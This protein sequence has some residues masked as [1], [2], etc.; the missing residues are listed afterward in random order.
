MLTF[1]EQITD[2][3]SGNI[4]FETLPTTGPESSTD[5]DALATDPAEI[6][7]FFGAI[8]GGHGRSPQHR[9][10]LPPV[11]PASITVDVQ[12]GT[13]ADGV[14]AFATELVRN[15]G[16][17]A[18]PGQRAVR[19]QVRQRAADHRDPLPGRCRRAPPSRWRPRSA[20]ASWSRT[21]RSRAATSWWWSAR[22]WIPR[23]RPRPPPRRRPQRRPPRRPPAAAAPQ[24]RRPPNQ[25]DRDR[26]DSAMRQLTA[27]PDDDSPLAARAASPPP[28]SAR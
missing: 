26:I 19:H 12:D 16:F 10:P 13:V 14:T 23:V 1:A 20:S 21:T 17:D 7:A 9:R 22:I 28:C 8:S 18:R 27:V 5:K 6:K 15:T 25:L 2:L 3:S 4:N 24:Q 11:D